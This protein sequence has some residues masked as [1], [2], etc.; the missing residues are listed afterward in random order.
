MRSL[1]L[2]L[3]LSVASA[4]IALAQASSPMADARHIIEQQLAALER[5]DAVEAYSY[6]APEIQAQFPDANL[7]LTM[8]SAAYAPMHRHRSVEFGPAA[9]QEDTVAETVIFTDDDGQVWTALYKL[10]KQPAG[11]WKISGCALAKTED[12]KGV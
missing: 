3:L 8:V 6:T 12:Q 9:E 10:D 7:F 11:G 1:A 5:D 2:G 4:P